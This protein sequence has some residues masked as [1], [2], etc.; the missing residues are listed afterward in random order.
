MVATEAYYAQYDEY[1]K[2]CRSGLEAANELPVEAMST[3]VGAMNDYLNQLSKV[4][5][6]MKTIGT[7]DSVVFGTQEY[8]RFYEL[9][10]EYYDQVGQVSPYTISSQLYNNLNSKMDEADPSDELNALDDQL[11]KSWADSRR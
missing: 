10:D 9:E 2:A 7:S 5:D 8:T 6:E 4:V 1:V 3:Y 11:Q